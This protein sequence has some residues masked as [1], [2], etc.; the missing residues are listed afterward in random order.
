MI[1]SLFNILFIKDEIP[2]CYTDSNTISET[3]CDEIMS[4]VEFLKEYQMNIMLVLSSICGLLAFFILVTKSLPPRRKLIFVTIEL[5]A[6][7]LLISDRMA[8]FYR[9]DPS[10]IAYWMVRIS[11]FTTFL[12]ILLIIFIFTI[13]IMELYQNDGNLKK[14]P[15]RLYLSCI[16]CAIAAVMLVISQFTG[17]YYTFDSMNQYHRAEGF[18]LCYLFPLIILILDMSVVLKYRSRVGRGMLITILLFT[19]VPVISSIVQIFTYGVS[20]TNITLAGLVVS[21]YVF[22]L[23]DLNDMLERANKRELE[24]VREDQKNMRLLFEQTATALANAIDA[25]DKYTHGHSR[26]VAEHEIVEPADIVARCHVTKEID[27]I[28]IRRMV[29]NLLKNSVQTAVTHRV[30]F[31][32]RNDSVAR[33][34][35]FQLLQAPPRAPHFYQ[36]TR[37]LTA[38]HQISQQGNSLILPLMSL[39]MGI[40]NG[41]DTFHIEILGLLCLREKKTLVLVRLCLPQFIDR[42]VVGNKLSE[43]QILRKFLSRIFPIAL[44]CKTLGKI[45]AVAVAYFFNFSP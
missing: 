20:L 45:F 11:N 37:I 28:H 1:R 8:Y 14:L 18:M 5:S 4:V 36:E 3:G 19:I 44:Q 40:F 17:L 29:D 10:R 43:I 39:L 16:L 42:I 25:K 6:M 9:G 41:V 32:I 30:I 15:K 33:R 7:F 38:F 31:Q 12:M 26:R 13:Y 34:T 24:L 2:E 23:R 22:S 35:C 27:G 21:L